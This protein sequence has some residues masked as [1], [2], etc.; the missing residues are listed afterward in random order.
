MAELHSIRWRWIWPLSSIWEKKF[1]GSG[2]GY[3]SIS[4]RVLKSLGLFLGSGFDL[5]TWA[6][7]WSCSPGKPQ[8]VENPRKVKK[9]LD[10]SSGYRKTSGLGPDPARSLETLIELTTRPESQ[11]FHFYT[12]FLVSSC[13]KKSY[14]KRDTEWI[15]TLEELCLN[16]GKAK[17]WLHSCHIVEGIELLWLYPPRFSW[18]IVDI[19]VL[20][21]SRKYPKILKIPKILGFRSATCQGNGGNV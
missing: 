13:S 6:G 1:L 2:I 14:K 15:D 8:A 10:L 18:L 17:T 4:V 7:S 12:K 5:L 16:F 21:P 19:S 3:E 20:I 11:K 9:C